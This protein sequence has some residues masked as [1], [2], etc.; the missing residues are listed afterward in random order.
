[1]SKKITVG[2][3]ANKTN[4]FTQEE[5]KVPVTEAVLDALLDDTV[6]DADTLTV[7]ERTAKLLRIDVGID[8]LVP[9]E[10]N[11]N[12][13]N[14][15]E[16]NMLYDNIERMGVTDP[17]LV[18]THPTE[19]GKY[20]IVGGYHRWEVAKLHGMETVPVTI[21]DDPEFDEDM[22]KFQLVRHNIIHGSMSPQRF[23]KLFDSL[24]KKYSDDVASEMFGFTDEEEFRKLVQLTAKGLPNE[25]QAQFKEAASE[26]KTIDDLAQ[27][28][29]RLFTAHGDTVPYNYMIFDYGKQ[30]HIWLRMKPA[31]KKDFED[32][33]KLCKVHSVTMDSVLTMLL[34]LT[35]QGA[36]SMHEFNARLAKLPTITIPSH[37]ELPT[38]E[39]LAVV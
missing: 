27:V 6:G 24:S 13:M 34:Q 5:A 8:E 9:N 15:A 39:T 20:R 38:E 21:I 36:L 35:A 26:I 3:K 4:K 12:Q 31:Q 1:M 37:V 16:F 29:N 17:I 7:Q 2:G 33:A 32:I 10:L 19:K 23:M 22:E 14:D 18:R 28:L 11:P 25:M 30:E